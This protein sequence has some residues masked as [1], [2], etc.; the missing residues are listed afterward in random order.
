MNLGLT[1][2]AGR[3]ASAVLYGVLVFIGVFIVGIILTKFTQTTDIGEFL[4][5]WAP[6]LGLLAGI[7][8]FLTGSKPVVT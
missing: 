4:K 2:L 8:A 3:V 5:S 1:G 6:L 7:V